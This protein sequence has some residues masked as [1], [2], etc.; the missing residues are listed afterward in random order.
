MASGLHPGGIAALPHRVATLHVGD[1]IG[2]G[3]RRQP[4]PN[5]ETVPPARNC[6]IAC[7]TRR[8]VRVSTEFVAS[9]WFNTAGAAMKTRASGEREQVE[10]GLNT[11]SSFGSAPGIC[12]GR[13]LWIRRAETCCRIGHRWIPVDAFIQVARHIFDVVLAP[14]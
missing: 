2:V 9:S 3:D 1:E 4:V 11:S 12:A 6:A 5:D 10:N 14:V 7:C 8:S 13:D